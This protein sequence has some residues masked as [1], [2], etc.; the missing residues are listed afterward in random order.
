MAAPIIPYYLESWLFK[1]LQPFCLAAKTHNFGS[2]RINPVKSYYASLI[3]GLARGH[4]EDISVE[5]KGCRICRDGGTFVAGFLHRRLNAHG[6]GRNSVSSTHSGCHG[7][8]PATPDAP[9]SGQKCC[10]GNHSP[11]ALLAAA[12]AVSVPLVSAKF[13]SNTIFGSCALSRHATEIVTPSSGPPGL[14]VLRI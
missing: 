13:V 14:L 1:Q 9:S 8:A 12:P 3:V 2:N 7:S 6:Y 5:W 11:E 4:L 10:N